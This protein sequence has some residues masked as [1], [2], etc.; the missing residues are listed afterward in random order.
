M[1]RIAMLMANVQNAQDTNW[2]WRRK[3]LRFPNLLPR[4]KTIVETNRNRSRK[5]KLAL[6]SYIYT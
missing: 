4:T 5:E 3:K 2:S 6:A 1:V